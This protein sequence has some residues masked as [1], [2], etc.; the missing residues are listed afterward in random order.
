M[1]RNGDYDVQPEQSESEQS[2]QPAE[3]ESEQPAKPEPSAAAESAEAESQRTELPQQQL[4]QITI[5]CFNQK[6]TLPLRAVTRNDRVVFYEFKIK[7]TISFA[8]NFVFL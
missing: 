8:K 3:P 7:I 1:R 6:T 5:S 4:R 2:E